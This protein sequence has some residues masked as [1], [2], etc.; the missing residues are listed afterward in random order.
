MFQIIQDL[1]LLLLVSLP[2]N[3]LFHRIKLPSVMGFLIAGI[4]IG[5][6][7]LQLIGELESVNH[8][9][10]IGVILLLFLIGFRVF[11]KPFIKKTLGKF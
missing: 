11:I 1:A 4:I 2:I 5:P 9:A 7:G 8:L 3:I 10:E 6:N